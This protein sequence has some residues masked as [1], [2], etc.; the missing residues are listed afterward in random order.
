[1]SYRVK[2][3]GTIDQRAANSTKTV[4]RRQDYVKYTYGQ[5][6]TICNR[7][8]SKLHIRFE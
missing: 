3:L 4:Y 8:G 5:N 6:M 7:L 1:M 2:F